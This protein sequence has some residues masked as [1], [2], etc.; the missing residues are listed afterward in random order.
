VV[1]S[2]D[3]LD[4]L[5]DLSQRMVNSGHKPSFIKRVMFVPNTRRGTLL[6][7]MK[8][9]EERHADMTGF[10]INY[11]EAASTKLGRV[12][13]LDLAKN[14]PFGTRKMQELQPPRRSDVQL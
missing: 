11:T 7:N 13:S 8:A 4:V 12:F 5:E 3:R 14:Q 6:K 1:R 9:N 10:K 2:Q